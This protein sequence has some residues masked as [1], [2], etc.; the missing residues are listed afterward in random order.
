MLLIGWLIGTLMPDGPYAHLAL[1]GEQGSAKSTTTRLLRAIVD[2]NEAMARTMPKE[3]RDL[4]IAAK[5]S[6][7]IAF[8]NLSYLP[9][10]LSDALCRLS[11]GAADGTRK[12]YSDDEEALFSA[13]RPVIFNGIEEIA[14]R[15]DL[16]DRLILVSL[17]PPT[18]RMPESELW[19]AFDQARPTILGGLLN[20]ASLA[21]RR[22]P[23]VQMDNLPR[24]ADF[25]LWV[26]A[27]APTLGWQFGDFTH[28][29]HVMRQ[30]AVSVQLESS[31]VA[32]AVLDMDLP[33]EGSATELHE[34][35]TRRISMDVKSLR[36][37]PR[38]PRALSGALTRLAPALRTV[39]IDV[40][41]VKS[42]GD[43]SLIIRSRSQGR[44]RGA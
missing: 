26:E 43:R 11:T 1:N 3:E 20:T 21:L 27:A 2:P 5:N 7:I 14:T 15:G 16:I 24:L 32:R 22:R 31:P 4:A 39:G 8:D 17:T 41:S 10:W 25:A 19:A 42:N 18:K 33:W 9:E 35:L 40:C 36:K 13:K 37:W 34:L 38:N 6:R 30:G 23:L 44:I 29:M 12:L 28:A